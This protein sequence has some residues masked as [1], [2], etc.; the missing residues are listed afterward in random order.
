MI[1]TIEGLVLSF[2]SDGGTLLL[3]HQSAASLT[4]VVDMYLDPTLEYPLWM[5]HFYW[6][7]IVKDSQDRILRRHLAK[8]KATPAKSKK[9]MSK[10]L[11]GRVV[12]CR[13]RKQGSEWE[14]FQIVIDAGQEQ[15]DIPYYER[16][17]SDRI[18]S[19][20]HMNR[21]LEKKLSRQNQTARSNVEKPWRG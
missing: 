20:S 15:H 13:V 8:S 2:S 19:Q 9:A 3:R 17:R 21:Q 6:D 7:A 10:W 18:K 1:K 12:T 14:A 5:A 11:V 4:F 16:I